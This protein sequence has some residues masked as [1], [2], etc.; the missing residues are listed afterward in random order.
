MF[1]TSRAAVPCPEDGHGHVEVPGQRAAAC[2]TCGLVLQMTVPCKSVSDDEPF[3]VLCCCNIFTNLIRI[4][5]LLSQLMCH[6]CATLSCSTTE[7]QKQHR[8]RG[9]RLCMHKG[10]ASVGRDVC[11]MSSCLNFEAIKV[12][13]LTSRGFVASDS[14][15]HKT[16]RTCK[17]SNFAGVHGSHECQHSTTTQYCYGGLACAGR[18]K[19]SLVQSAA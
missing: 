7:S 17:V 12:I 3:Y 19:I 14:G 9:A 2:T 13:L 18:Y 11:E 8:A 1:I 6:N 10:C 5:Q 15:N 16:G 4:A